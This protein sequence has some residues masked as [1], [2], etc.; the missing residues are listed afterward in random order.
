MPN[1]GAVNRASSEVNPAP[2]RAMKREV[3][4]Q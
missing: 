3:Q 2:E 1:I 4:N